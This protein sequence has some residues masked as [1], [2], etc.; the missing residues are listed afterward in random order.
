VPEETHCNHRE[1]A[2]LFEKGGGDI[3]PLAPAT[4]KSNTVLGTGQLLFL[5]KNPFRETFK[6]LFRGE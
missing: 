3:F 1:S 4:F 6:P 2:Y 5:P